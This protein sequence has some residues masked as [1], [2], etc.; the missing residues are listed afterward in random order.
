MYRIVNYYSI[1]QTKRLQKL[2][3]EGKNVYSADELKSIWGLSGN[4]FRQTVKR[5][6]DKELLIRLAKGVYAT[7]KDFDK[8]ELANTLVTPSYVSVNSALVYFDVAFQVLTTVNSVATY[9]YSREVGKTTYKYFTIKDKI[10]FDTVGL[11]QK[12]NITIATPER[13]ICD[14]FYLDVLV[15]IDNPDQ[16]NKQNFTDIKEIYPDTV[17]KKV[18]KLVQNYGL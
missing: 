1:K 6:V 7:T 15:N 5:M 9:S 18:N 17:K 16:L 11:K 14:A 12:N 2:F 13:A 10:F 8:F 3:N 4:T